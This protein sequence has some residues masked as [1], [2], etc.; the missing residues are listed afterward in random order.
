MIEITI[1]ARFPDFKRINLSCPEMH[2]LTG[3]LKR[4]QT[5]NANSDQRQILACS[6][7]LLDRSPEKDPN[8]ED[9]PREN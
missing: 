8:Y 7:I 1:H 4:S 3:P 6:Q 9:V 5:R 2:S